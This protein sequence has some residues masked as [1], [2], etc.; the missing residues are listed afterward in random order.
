GAVDTLLTPT[1][2]RWNGLTSENST[3]HETI[4]D[5]HLKLAYKTGQ[6]D[7]LCAD[8][9]QLWTRNTELN[10]KWRVLEMENVELRRDNEALRTDLY[11]Y[12]GVTRSQRSE[13][14]PNEANGGKRS[15]GVARSELQYLSETSPAK[16]KSQSE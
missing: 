6:M 8:N 14:P 15:G 2:E 1:T 5:L 12:K 3:Q 7:Q 16:K 10:D 11:V 9:N 4:Q 13:A